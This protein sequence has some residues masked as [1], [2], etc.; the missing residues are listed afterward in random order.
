MMSLSMPPVQQGGLTFR[1]TAELRASA[2]VDETRRDE[3]GVQYA[4]VRASVALKVGGAAAG[5][6]V[7]PCTRFQW[8]WLMAPRST[9]TCTMGIQMSRF[10][11]RW[12]GR[13]D[14]RARHQLQ[15]QLAKGN[16]WQQH[17]FGKGKKRL[18]CG[19]AGRRAFASFGWP[20]L[21]PSP[22]LP[23]TIRTGRGFTPGALPTLGNSTEDPCLPDRVSRVRS[24]KRERERRER[25]RALAPLA[26]AVADRVRGWETYGR[27]TKDIFTCTF[28]FESKG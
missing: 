17:L 4:S 6:C 18:W 22:P 28:F 12:E 10:G 24:M 2:L 8:P 7:F 3:K 5:V 9:S 14:R 27:Q 23:A 26:V 13:R 11:A 25:G 20:P 19:V 1:S 15:L 21:R 16:G